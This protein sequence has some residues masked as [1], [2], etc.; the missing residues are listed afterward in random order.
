MADTDPIEKF[1]DYI[2]Q[3]DLLSEEELDS[4][5]EESQKDI[6]AAVQFA[7]D[8]PEPDPEALYEDVLA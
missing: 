4:L 3:E 8:S 2:L 5:A 7:E 6:E 1:R